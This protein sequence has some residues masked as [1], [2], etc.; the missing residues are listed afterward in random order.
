MYSQG[1]FKKGCT[2]VYSLAMSFKGSGFDL[3]GENIDSP[4]PLEYTLVC[5]AS[6]KGYPILIMIGVKL[7][8]EYQALYAEFETQRGEL[9]NAEKLFDLSIT[10][11][12]NMV[13]MEKEL[14]NVAMVFELYEAQRVCEYV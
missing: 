3:Q 2:K 14:K 8:K 12:P 4:A 5:N 10:G 1:S 13:E 7:L 11:Y 6:I 9:T